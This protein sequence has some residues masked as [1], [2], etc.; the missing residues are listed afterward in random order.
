MCS[1]S[2]A[3]IF[4]AKITLVGGGSDTVTHRA[5]HSQSLTGKPWHFV[6]RSRRDRA[7]SLPGSIAGLCP[8]LNPGKTAAYRGQDVTA[9]AWLGCN[10]QKFRTIPLHICCSPLNPSSLASAS[11]ESTEVPDLRASLLYRRA[12][13]V[14]PWSTVVTRD[15][16]RTWLLWIPT[17]IRSDP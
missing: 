9:S 2:Y 10:V 12:C 4:S 5:L 8:S 16:S 11:R 13:S 17:F 15:V 6:T 7:S 1:I 3:Y 14:C